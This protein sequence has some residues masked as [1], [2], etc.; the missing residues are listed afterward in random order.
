LVGIVVIA[1]VTAVACGGDGQAGEEYTGDISGEELIERVLAS[2][3]EQETAQ[4]TMII[5]G[6]IKGTIEGEYGEMTYRMENTG[7]I[8][9]VDR[10]M[11][12]E[13][14]MTMSSNTEGEAEQYTLV[15]K[16]Y[17]ID[18][19]A[20]VGTQEDGG[21]T[22]WIKGDMS[23]ELWESYDLQNQQMEMLRYAEV[24]IVGT[25]S[26]RGVP[27][28]VAE[29]T[30][31]PGEIMEMMDTQFTGL[32]SLWLG[33][34]TIRNFESEGWYAQATYFPMRATN[35]YDIVFEQGDDRLT[36]HYS[37][38]MEMYDYNKPVTVHLPPD[39]EGAEYIGPLD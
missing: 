14:T 37:T 25:Q 30:L 5:D 10:E 31:D 21:P 4:F 27:C 17:F 12:Q 3:D 32:E 38:F 39:A 18:D 26:A 11:L 23:E 15:M 13:M 19:L 36:G 1:G 20:Y 8:D 35:E 29:I 9:L 7:A 6:N 34:D 22:Y 28:Y 2:A 16:T 33:E 24:R